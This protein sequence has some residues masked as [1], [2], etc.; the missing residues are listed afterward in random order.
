MSPGAEK[1]ISLIIGDCAMNCVVSVSFRRVLRN[2]GLTLL[3]PVRR[4]Y[5]IMS[6]REID[7]ENPSEMANRMQ[8]KGMYHIN[9]STY[10]DRDKMIKTCDAQD[11]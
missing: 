6:T 5:V 9:L 2:I 3:V 1:W 11:A 10:V 4:I 8:F 7:T